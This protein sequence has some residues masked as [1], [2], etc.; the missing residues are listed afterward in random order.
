M[1]RILLSLLMLLAITSLQAQKKK[2]TQVEA[3]PVRTTVSL[4]DAMKMYDFETAEQLVNQEIASLKKNQ[5]ETTDMEALLPWLQ[6]AQQ[7]L[8]AVEQITFIDSII[9]PIDEASRHIPLSM[10]CGAIYRSSDY[11]QYQGT[12]LDRTVFQ[13]QMG[14]KIIYSDPNKNK[15]LSLYTRDIYPDGTQSQPSV[16]TGVSDGNKEDQNY[17]FMLTDGTTLYFAAQNPDGLGG[18]DIYMTRYDADER[19]FLTPENI[20]MPF[21]SAANDYLYVIDEINH[22]GWF[23]TD[24]NM[25]IGKVCV[26]TFIPNE[27][28]KIYDVKDIPAWKLQDLARI[29]RIQDT[30]TNEEEVKNALVRLN[31]ARNPQA[32]YSTSAF[33]F[34]VN[35]DRVCH[36]LNDFHSSEAQKKVESWINAKNELEQTRNKLANMRKDFYS[37]TATHRNQMRRNII[38][39]ELNEENLVVLIRKIENDMRKLELGL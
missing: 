5:Q 29:N 23:I 39:L 1:K 13:S 8:K 11:F 17:P 38:K 37:S 31:E 15:V 25:P 30:W 6:K 20:G 9:V 19:C 14:D 24:R 10:E 36:N 3:T 32:S 27:T 18:Y 33:D 35:D 26:Y 34:I 21:N 7:K 12:V 22:L 4:K 16:L 28:R 2:K